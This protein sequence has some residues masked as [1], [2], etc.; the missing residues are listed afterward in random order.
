MSGLEVAVT[1]PAPATAR[2]QAAPGAGKTPASTTR[3][4]PALE[5]RRPLHLAV[6][7]GASTALYA[8]SLAGVTALQSSTDA[9][10]VE[11][12]APVSAAADRLTAG[13]DRLEDAV[14]AAEGHY[15]DA[16][17]AYDS[18]TRK[19]AA[20]E[21]SLAANANRMSAIG[22][23]ANSLPTKVS[24][25]TVSRTVTKTVSKPTVRSTTG[26][27]GKP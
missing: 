24:L 1:G 25:P 15:S 27:S 26:A 19:L 4:P 3:K 13:H 23:A 12:Q 11:D 16:A 17:S 6:L 2:P 18:L 5:P 8:A 7:A 22:G 21:A 10:R 20:M 9:A 14:T